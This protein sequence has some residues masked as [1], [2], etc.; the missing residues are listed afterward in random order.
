MM[1]QLVNHYTES[2]EVVECS[3]KRDIVDLEPTCLQAEMGSVL[4]LMNSIVLALDGD[5]RLVVDSG[6]MG[7]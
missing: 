4:V 7:P 6:L 3:C 2:I 1:N 5:M